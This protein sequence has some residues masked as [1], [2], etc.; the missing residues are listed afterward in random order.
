MVAFRPS[1]LK[2]EPTSPFILHF[3]RADMDVQPSAFGGLVAY[4]NPFADELTIHWHG[5]AAVKSLSIN[6]A[7][8]RLVSHLDCD[9]LLNG[10]CRWNATQLERGVY[11]IH[12]VTDEGRF[13][14]RI[15]K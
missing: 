14:V 15:V 12:A 13:A 5:D 2:G 7:N 11:F 6:D 8:G 4:P 10:P 9:G 1:S 3:T